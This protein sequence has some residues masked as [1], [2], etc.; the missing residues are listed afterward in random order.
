MSKREN[1]TFFLDEL[2]ALLELIE[3]INIPNSFESKRTD[4]KLLKENLKKVCENGKRLINKLNQANEELRILNKNLE[5]KAIMLET[6]ISKLNVAIFVFDV[7][8]NGDFIFQELNP[9]HEEL[10]GFKTKEVKGKKPK[11]FLPPDIANEIEKNY[12]K[13]VQTKKV[14]EYEEKLF[15]K[16]KNTWWLTRLIPLL[17]GERVYRIVGASININSYKEVIE[18]LNIK[19]NL[20]ESIYKIMPV[21]FF[22]K[23]KDFK[24]NNCNEAFENL[25]EIKKET[26]LK[27]KDNSI[28]DEAIKNILDEK[29]NELTINRDP[30]EFE[31]EVGEKFLIFKLM[32]INKD[33]EFNGYV[34]SVV[35]IS[36]Q[37]KYQKLLED[38]AIKDELTGLYNRRGLSD[39]IVRE[40]RN[41]IREQQPISILMIDVDNF[42][43]YN[44]TYGHKEGDKSLK[45]ISEI[46]VKNTFRPTDIVSR[47]GGE[48]FLIILPKTNFAGALKVA[49]R[50][51][52][53]VFNSQIKHKNS[54]FGVITVSI[55][56]STSVPGK[57]EKYEDLIED[58]DKNLYIAKSKG[59]NRV[60]GYYYP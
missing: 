18:E 47:I 32:P 25:F 33:G 38:L 53:A 12:T 37:K 20:T 48:E 40:W 34:C 44:D 28:F 11:D 42:K 13:C 15:L 23:G 52:E 7:T 55:G 58:A 24:F 10:T 4:F 21:P 8:E 29:E 59:K 50:I 49:E 43:N 41:A 1:I 6:L 27:M 16:G 57:F 5:D 3:E 46:M 56:I 9:T 19:N 54:N 35:D 31:V 17:K 26:L 60:E 51:R 14:I 2:K 36:E 30:I 22:S 39:F 45:I